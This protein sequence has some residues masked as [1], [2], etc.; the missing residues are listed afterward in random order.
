MGAANDRM[1]LV[2]VSASRRKSIAAM[3]AAAVGAAVATPSITKAGKAGKKAK[4]RCRS[5]EE[6]CVG[7]GYGVCGALIPSGG[8]PLAKCLTDMTNCCVPLTHC[9]ADEYFACINT[10]LTGLVPL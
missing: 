6:A 1:E 10:A 2:A 8:D 7:F 4:K 3:V 9:K 5:Q